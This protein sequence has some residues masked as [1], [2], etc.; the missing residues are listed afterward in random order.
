[1]ESSEVYLIESKEK[2]KKKK[3]HQKNVG[4]ELGLV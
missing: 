2:K 3:G 1:M 4:D